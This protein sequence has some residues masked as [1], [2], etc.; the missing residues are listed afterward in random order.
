MICCATNSKSRCDVGPTQY[1]CPVIGPR[2]IPEFFL[3]IDAAISDLAS[4]ASELMIS[5]NICTR[6]QVAAPVEI[7]LRA[8]ASGAPGNTRSAMIVA[9][10]A[11]PATRAAQPGKTQ[12]KQCQ[13]RGRRDTG[14][15][16]E[17][18]PGVGAVERILKGGIQ[19]SDGIL[20]SAKR[21]DIAHGLAAHEHIRLV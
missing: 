19:Q 3:Y 17:S 13:C 2:A 20:V 9:R 16:I 4:A 6:W 8:P 10:S 18:Y 5:P 1:A 7:R 12:S 15:A 14:I 11:G 21:R